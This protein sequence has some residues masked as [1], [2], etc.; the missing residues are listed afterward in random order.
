M[1]LLR[2]RW[3]R[4]GSERFVEAAGSGRQTTT[5]WTLEEGQPRHRLMGGR[6]GS[7]MGSRRLVVA[8]E[9]MMAVQRKRQI[10]TGAA[11]AA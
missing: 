8:A 4:E 6:E 11:W 2:K 5:G 7:K 3:I 10:R 1:V 9:K